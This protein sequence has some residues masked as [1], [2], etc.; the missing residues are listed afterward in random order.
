MTAPVGRTLIRNLGQSQI[1]STSEAF[2]RTHFVADLA[3][4]LVRRYL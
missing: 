2:Q 4:G 1:G 3:A